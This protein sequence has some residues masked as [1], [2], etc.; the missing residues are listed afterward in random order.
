MANN[1]SGSG[2]SLAATLA[3][4]VGGGGAA[5][6]PPGLVGGITGAGASSVAAALNSTNSDLW[7]ECVLWLQRCKVLPPDHVATEEIRSLALTLRDGVMLCN[8]VIFLDPKCLDPGEMTKRPQ[9]AQVS[10]CVC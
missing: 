7:K 4:G 1:S 10:L 3:G 9:M 2:G 8:L 5:A 6:C